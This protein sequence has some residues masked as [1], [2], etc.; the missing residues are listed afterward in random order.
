MLFQ[1]TVIKFQ[2]VLFAQ[3]TIAGCGFSSG[4]DGMSEWVGD[5]CQMPSQQFFSFKLSWQEQVAF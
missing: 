2:R 1:S 4:H 5:S 3:I